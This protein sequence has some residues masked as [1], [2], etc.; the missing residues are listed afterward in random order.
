MSWSKRLGDDQFVAAAQFL[1]HSGCRVVLLGAPGEDQEHGARIG[2]RVSGVLDL[3]GQTPL[4]L[5]AGVLSGARVV[6]GNDSALAHLAAVCGTP[7]VVAF[8]PTDPSMTSP[9]GPWVRIVRDESLSCLVCQKGAC[10]VEGH[11]CMKLLD[12]ELICRAIKEG[13]AHLA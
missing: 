6:L 13:L 2:Q 5:A 3:T 12:P 7:V 10:P 9:R 8:G 11:P 4:S 1:E